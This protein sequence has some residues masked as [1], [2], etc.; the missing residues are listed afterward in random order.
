MTGKGIKDV[1]GQLHT[2]EALASAF[3]MIMV[4]AIVVQ[5]TSLTPLSS[6]YT[7]QHIKL[8]LQNMGNDILTSLDETP[9]SDT[10][11]PNCPSLL[12]QSIVDWCIYHYYDVYSWTGLEFKSIRNDDGSTMNTPLTNAL[13]YALVQRGVAFNVE[14]C[15]SD[16]AGVSRTSKMIWNGD[17]S[18]NSVVVS[19]FIVLHDDYNEIPPG[20]DKY[21]EN[22]I[23]PDISP[24]TRLHNVAEVRMTLWVM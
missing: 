5:T 8:E 9:V 10:T 24:S 13:R 6:S 11:D 2:I 16:P 14:V 23:L 19:R 3:I 22:D 15:Y 18:E 20:A 12:K 7:N 1:F 21:D 17:P 4:L